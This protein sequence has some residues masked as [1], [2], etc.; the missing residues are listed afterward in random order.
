M[1]DSR[2]F[3]LSDPIELG[4]LARISGA[5]L[6][7]RGL[8]T[9]L[10]RQ[11]GGLLDAGE[12]CVT[13][14]SGRRHIDQASS[15]KADACFVGPADAGA[16]PDH[17]APLICG[18]PNAAFAA[19]ADHLHRPRRHDGF[20]GL[21]HPT[22]RLEDGVELAPNVVIGQ[23]VM[24][25]RG[26]YL[27]PGVVIGPG[28]CIGR[29]G[30][31]GAQASIGFAL[32]GD[33]VRIHAG[34]LIGE[35]GFGAAAGPGGLVDMPQLGRVIIQDG[36]TIGAGTCIDRGAIDDTVIGEN[37]KIDNLVQIAHNVVIG[38]NCVLAAHTGISGSVSIG[39][40]CQLGGRAGVADHITIGAGARIAA[41]AG[42]MRNVPAG[43]SWGGYP[44]RP[45]KRWLRETAFLAQLARGRTE[46]DHRND[47]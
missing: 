30:F 28:V 5:T 15:T 35:P 2:F 45:V 40:G 23:G 29:D 8:S 1:P 11:V 33:R 3:E 7:A 14:F 4:A 17:C 47:H 46:G 44:A 22:A 10:I 12:G 19:A 20:G 25:G 18:T 26:T 24:I 37:S 9:R 43:E 41:A 6:H 42:V 27:G 34:T 21:I 13:F 38:R 39:D 16:L 31:V 36:V 32:I